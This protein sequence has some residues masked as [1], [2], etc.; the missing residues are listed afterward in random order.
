MKDK[1]KYCSN[2][3]RQNILNSEVFSF[4][5]D[6]AK[7]SL[8]NVTHLQTGSTRLFYAS[9]LCV[10]TY[11]YESVTACKPI[12]LKTATAHTNTHTHSSSMAFEV[13]AYVPM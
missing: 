13:A 12:R 1:H 3:H 9:I 6:N 7:R 4:I 10:R 2:H 11:T 5:K 8:L